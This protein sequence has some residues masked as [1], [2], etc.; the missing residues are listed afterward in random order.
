MAYPPQ[1]SVL[2]HLSKYKYGF[3]AILAKFPSEFTTNE[4]P[5]EGGLDLTPVVQ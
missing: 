5:E 2:L 4:F 1:V 3:V